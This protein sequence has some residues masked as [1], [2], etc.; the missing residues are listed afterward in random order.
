MNSESN[1]LERHVNAVVAKAFG[2]YS[3]DPTLSVPEP[4]LI[5][6]G[7]AGGLPFQS[8]TTDLNLGCLPPSKICYGS[9]FAARA[10]F[11]AGFN[12]GKRVENILDEEVFLSDLDVLPKSQGYLRNGWNSDPS[13]SWG[14]ALRLSELIHS[15]GRHTIFITKCFIAP[16]EAI[17]RGLAA[18]GVE[19]R[20]SVSAFDTKSQLDCRI[21]AI[22]DYRKHGGVAIPLLMTTRFKDPSLNVKQDEIFQYVVEH[23]LPAAE[24]SLRFKDSSPVLELIDE[25]AC[26]RV[27]KSGDIWCGR[28]YP[29]TAVRIPTTTSI[30]PHYQ[31]LQSPN[32]SENDSKFLKSL[33]YEPVPTH[34]EVKSKGLLDKPTKCGV[35]LD[36]NQIAVQVR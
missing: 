6:A 26:S 33:W 23:D 7:K 8:L 16:S 14:K 31:G 25:S 30:P 5:R 10:A 28:L 15:S 20:V 1:S 12:F 11:N 35:P 32:L 21:N 3:L 18:L 36:W 13:W 9:C 29:D 27:V 24:N 19:L 34:E 2:H 4:Q 17:M 22:E